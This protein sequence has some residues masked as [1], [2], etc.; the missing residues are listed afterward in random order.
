M[1][2]HTQKLAPGN[3]TTKFLFD[4]QAVNA[5]FLSSPSLGQNLPPIWDWVHKY[6][7]GFSSIF[8]ISTRQM[9][10]QGSQVFLWAF[11]HICS[12]QQGRW[13]SRESFADQLHHILIIFS[14]L[15]KQCYSLFR[16]V[17]PNTEEPYSRPFLGLS[18]IRLVLQDHMSPK[19]LRKNLALFQLLLHLQL[20]QNALFQ[21]C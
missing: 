16:L 3:W 15:N 20:Q 12:S 10:V 4:I 14:G 21:W 19:N 1:D 9:A 7:S 18:K 8:L 2:N 11:I 5:L 13:Q 6:F 17:W